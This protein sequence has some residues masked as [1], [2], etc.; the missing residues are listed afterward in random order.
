MCFVLKVCSVVGSSPQRMFK[1][2]LR[3]IWFNIVDCLK[4][5]GL[6][7]LSSAWGLLSRGVP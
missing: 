1:R 7:Y 2:E 6:F 4:D 3:D 5:K